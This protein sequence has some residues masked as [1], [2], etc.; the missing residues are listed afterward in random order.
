MK[1]V[2]K[3]FFLKLMFKNLHEPY[4]DLLFLFKLKKV[5]KVKKLVANL[6][7][8]K[9]YIIHIRNLKHALNHGLVLKKNHKVIKFNQKDWL[10]SYINMNTDLSKKKQKTND[11]F[12]KRFLQTNE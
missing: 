4:I 12:K 11:D 7:A 1:K 5:D 3:D 9:W 6:W 10:K 2:M 8:K